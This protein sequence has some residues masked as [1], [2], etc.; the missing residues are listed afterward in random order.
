MRAVTR[1]YTINEC[2][3]PKSNKIWVNLPL[4]NNTRLIITFVASKEGWHTYA[5]LVVL[6]LK[7]DDTL[8]D[9]LLYEVVPKMGLV[10]PP[11]ATNDTKEV[12][13]HVFYH[14]GIVGLVVLSVVLTTSTAPL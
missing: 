1:S 4:T 12:D 6:G 9:V 8:A 11:A 10:A 7:P 3:G 5:I 14:L 2:D 13:H